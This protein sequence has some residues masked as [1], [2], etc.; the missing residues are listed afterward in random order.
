[1]QP[2]LHG[3]LYVNALGEEDFQHRIQKAY[4]PKTY[5]RLVAL[6][7]KYD[8]T[9]LLRLNPN[10]SRRYRR[11]P[12][13][14]GDRANL[15]S[16][17]PPRRTKACSETAPRLCGRERVVELYRFFLSVEHLALVEWN[18]GSHARPPVPRPSGVGYGRMC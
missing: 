16:L 14:G 11:S 6:K 12:R 10:I 15:A 1:M 5:E 2:F 17:S 9:N 3:S 4:R 13:R 8:P 7:N 18:R